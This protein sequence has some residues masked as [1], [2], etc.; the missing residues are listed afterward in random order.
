MNNFRQK[1]F[2]NLST[3]ISTRIDLNKGK[4]EKKKEKN[5]KKKK[6]EDKNRKQI[7]K[8]R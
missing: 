1:T 6:K 5:N 7:I 2:I 4:K 8:K 3:E